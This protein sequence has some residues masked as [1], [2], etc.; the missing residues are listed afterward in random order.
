MVKNC[1][2]GLE[3]ASLGLQQKVYSPCLTK[4]LV[5]EDFVFYDCSYSHMSI[6]RAVLQTKQLHPGRMKRLSN[7]PEKRKK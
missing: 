6:S 1:D 4:L 3:N 7:R 2:R 5:D